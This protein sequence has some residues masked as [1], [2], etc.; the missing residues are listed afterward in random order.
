MNKSKI[1]IFQAADSRSG[2]QVGGASPCSSGRQVDPP[3]TGHN[4]HLR[5][6][7]THPHSLRQAQ[8][9]HANSPQVHIFGMCEEI[10]AQRKPMQTCGHRANHTEKWPRPGI[11][12]FFH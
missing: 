9:R 11:K 12:F 8:R 4:F 2:S 3:G 6:I 1:I 7:H 10:G 5:A